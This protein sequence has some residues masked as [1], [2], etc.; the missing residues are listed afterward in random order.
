MA[1]ARFAPDFMIMQRRK[2][3]ENRRIYDEKTKANSAYERVAV[4]EHKT[5]KTIERGQVTRKVQSMK[6]DLEQDLEGRRARLAALLAEEDARYTLELEQLEETPELRRDRLKARARELVR[7]R[8]QEKR[9]FAKEMRERQFRETCDQFREYDGVYLLRECKTQCD[10]AMIERGEEKKRQ[11]EEAAMWHNRLL[12]E[13]RKAERR[14]ASDSNRE[15]ELRSEMLRTLQE[16]VHELNGRR[17]EDERLKAEEARL[18]KERFAL[19]VAEARAKEEARAEM[20]A[21]KKVAIA[22]HNSILRAE[23][24]AEIR[25]QQ[26]EDLALLNAMLDKERRAEAAEMAYKAS[27]KAQAREYQAQLIELMKKEAVDEAASEA[28]REAEQDKAWRKREEVWEKEKGAREKLM[29]DVMTVRRQ[30]LDQRLEQNKLDREAALNT[31]E[32]M[33]NAVEEQE[34]SRILEAKIRKNIVKEHQHDI[35][36]QIDEA[37]GRMRRDME[38]AALELE[39]SRREEE[40]YQAKLQK[41]MLLAANGRHKSHGLKSTG[42]F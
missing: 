26:E 33:M 3:E 42:L 11:K 5:G 20:F 24:E 16:Q 32:G 40:A 34:A 13:V 1:T 30:Q 38:I 36:E 29:K 18:M 7:R 2:E 6:R 39:A 25:R 4:W 21:E 22:R 27:L 12:D 41:E 17:G 28:I 31:R 8:E 37:K 23:K 15:S 14:E 9:D 10:N 35:L 19:D